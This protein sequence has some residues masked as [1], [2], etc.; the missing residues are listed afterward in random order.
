MLNK[1]NSWVCAMRSCS[2]FSEPSATIS[3][4]DLT[5]AANP[6]RVGAALYKDQWHQHIKDFYE[7]ITLKLLTEKSCKIAG[8]NQVDIT[9][10]YE[11]PG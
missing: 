1:G 9:R 3:I 7:H 5:V 4:N 6:Y 8:I 2:L 11:F 10:E